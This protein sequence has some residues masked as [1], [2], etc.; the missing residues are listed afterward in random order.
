MLKPLN[1]RELLT[2]AG[3]AGLPLCLGALASPALAQQGY[4]NKPIRIVV[5]FNAGGATDVLTRLIGEKLSARLWQPVLVDNRGGAGGIVGTDNV[6]KAAPDGYTFVVSLNSSLM[7]NLFLYDKL[8]YHPQRDL[9]LVSQFVNAPVTLVVHPSVPAK[10]GPE[11]LKYIA[12]NKGKLSY[13]SWGVGSY[14]HLAGYS[15]SESQKADMVHAP[16]KGEAPMLQELIGGQI[17]MSYASAL[18][19]KPHIEAGKLKLIGVTG[20]KRMAVLPNAP[21]LTEQGLTDEFYR[22]A[23]WI[24]MAAPAKTPK[25]IIA[26]VSSE[27]QRICVMPEIV[28]RISSMG[29]TVAASTPEAFAAAYKKDSPVWERLVKTSGARLDL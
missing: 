11:L 21:T 24:G 23:G 26:R 10:N 19:A 20:L 17:Q 22:I 15:M 1:R 7:T 6:A 29:F 18:A 13:G 16:Y 4:P 3:S 27:I 28:E 14:A 12:A 8:P 9:T 5:P 25:D 2:Q